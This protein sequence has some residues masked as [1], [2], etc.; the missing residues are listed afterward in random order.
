MTDS[1]LTASS[2]WDLP[3]DAD[4]V[5]S[6]EYELTL[7]RPGA[8]TDA[9]ALPA[10][11]PAAARRFAES[12][13]TID[14]VLEDLGT[15]PATDGAS[16]GTRADL[17]LVRVGSWGGV[18]EITDPGLVHCDGRFPVEE[19][20]ESLA[21]RFP[22]A[23]IIASCTIDHHM[24]YG[25]YKIIHPDGTRLF[26]AGW[27]GESL[28]FWDLDGSPAD[29]VGA[30]GIT[31]AELSDAWVDMDAAANTFHW[32]GLFR[33]ALQKVAPLDHTGRIESVFRVR[34]TEHAIG[35][36]EEVWLE[37]E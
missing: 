1:S 10:H 7:V 11:D 37:A 32:E 20:A 4:V 14:A 6:G 17:E 29:V 28:D 13:G 19:E 8:P 35:A 21:E 30:F 24:T 2:L 26:A 15:V 33:L 36:M 31:A 12:F 23:V 5:R 16:A 25:A 9:A 27:Y 22:D 18:T 34:H 3:P